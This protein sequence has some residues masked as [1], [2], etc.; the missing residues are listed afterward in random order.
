MTLTNGASGGNPGGMFSMPT[1]FDAA[2]FS[3]TTNIQ[4]LLQ[5]NND[6]ILAIH[7]SIVDSTQ[8]LNRK[9]VNI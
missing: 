9:I 1:G 2:N 4:L 3:A 5:T 6:L 8:E 7:K